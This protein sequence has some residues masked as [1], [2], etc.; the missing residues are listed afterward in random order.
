MHFPKEQ[1]KRARFVKIGIAAGEPFDADKLGPEIRRV[2]EGGMKAG[3]EK[4]IEKISK[5]GKKK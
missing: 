2:I 3:N 5:I 4:I 1:P